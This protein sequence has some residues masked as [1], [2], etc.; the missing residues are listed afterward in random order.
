MYDS[1]FNLFQLY[2]LSHKIVCVW[3]HKLKLSEQYD[4]KSHAR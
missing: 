2:I 3:S 1:Y 4:I